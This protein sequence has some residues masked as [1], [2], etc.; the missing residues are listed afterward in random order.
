MKLIT[1]VCVALILCVMGAVL[2]FVEIGYAADAGNQAVP[3]SKDVRTL[4]IAPGVTTNTSSS[5]VAGVAGNKTYW[6]HVTGTGTVGATV[7]HLGCQTNST[8]YCLSLGTITLSGTTT[9][10][11]VTTPA[12]GNANY[13]YHYITTTGVTGTGATV[14]AGVNY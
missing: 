14:S 10:Y 3:E 12:V 1:R 2:P 5:L 7:E 11:D 9:D 4:T 8:T 6:A 13:P